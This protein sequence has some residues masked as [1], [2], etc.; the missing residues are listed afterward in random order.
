MSV[1]SAEVENLLLQE[2]CTKKAQ[3]LLKIL[4]ENIIKSIIY[5]AT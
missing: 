1:K 4:K 3:H 5:R 2:L